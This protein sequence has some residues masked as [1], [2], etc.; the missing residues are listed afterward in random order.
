MAHPPAAQ[1]PAPGRPKE[2]WPER[3]QAGGRGGAAVRDDLRHD[4]LLDLRDDLLERVLDALLLDLAGAV[5]P[6]AAAAGVGR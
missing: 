4:G 2:R 5:A 6:A 1:S 3:R